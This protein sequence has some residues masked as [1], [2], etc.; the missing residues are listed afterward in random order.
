MRL[1][2]DVFFVLDTKNDDRVR[3]AVTSL[4]LETLALREREIVAECDGVVVDVR[5]AEGRCEK[6]F[7][8]FDADDVRSRDD[9]SDFDSAAVIVLLAEC[10]GVG[11]TVKDFENVL[12]CGETEVEIVAP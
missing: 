4:V 7:A 10:E 8:V 3:L 2:D 6:E 12:S 1:I 11:V 5:E 9:D